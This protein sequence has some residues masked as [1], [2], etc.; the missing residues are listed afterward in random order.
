MRL[1]T[2]LFTDE[3]RGRFISGW[4]SAGGY[5]DDLETSAPWCCPWYW[6]EVIEVNGDTPEEWGADWWRQC[7]PQILEEIRGIEG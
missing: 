7:K 1:D 2:T 6:H 5:I 3:E 4:N